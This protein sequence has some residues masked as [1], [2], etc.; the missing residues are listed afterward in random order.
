MD[1]VLGM[2]QVLIFVINALVNAGY[3]TNLNYYAAADL[4]A[5]SVVLK[6]CSL[7]Q[8]PTVFGAVQV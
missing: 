1:Q 8:D 6:S 3:M 7:N 5:V 2:S 4:C